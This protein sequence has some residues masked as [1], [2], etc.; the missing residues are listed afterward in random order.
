MTETVFFKIKELLDKNKFAYE[1]IDHEP[2]H[3]SLDAAR[4]RGSDISNGAKALVLIGDK[5]P[6]LFV[7][8]ANLKVS[9]KEV[10]QNL[11]IKDLRMASKE[12]VLTLTT[13]QVG[14]IPPLGS[15]IGLPTVFDESFT[16][17]EKVIFNA[18]M[19]T[20]SIQMN[21]SDLIHVETPKLAKIAE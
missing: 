2:V 21:A 9:F 8:P 5:V 11:S 13:L 12:E 4:V 7:V 1:V 14:S 10:K 16:K 3:T 15:C 18:G 20:R 6:Y 19:L 17:K